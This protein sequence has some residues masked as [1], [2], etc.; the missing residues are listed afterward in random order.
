MVKESCFPFTRGTISMSTQT[1][2]RWQ[3]H[4]NFYKWRIKWSNA[5]M[6]YSPL[7]LFQRNKKLAPVGVSKANNGME[8]LEFRL[9]CLASWNVFLV[10][11]LEF[12]NSEKDGKC[13]IT[14][15]LKIVGR[16]SLWS[17]GS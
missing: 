11:I 17:N 3:V 7:I 9:I 6:L 2:W 5:A 4:A 10:S 16:S 1:Q 8:K 14:G 12:G 15:R 13:P